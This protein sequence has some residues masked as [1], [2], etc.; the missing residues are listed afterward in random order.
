MFTARLC[1]PPPSPCARPC[2]PTSQ[3]GPSKFSILFANR[4]GGLSIADIINGTDHDDLVELCSQARPVCRVIRPSTL[5][6]TSP[7]PRSRTVAV[8]CHNARLGRR[9]L[10]CVFSLPHVDRS[11]GERTRRTRLLA[12]LFDRR[13]A[14]RRVARRGILGRLFTLRVALGALRHLARRATRRTLRHRRNFS[15]LLPLAACRRRVFLSTRC[16]TRLSIQGTLRGS[17]LT[18]AACK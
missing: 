11:L 2:P 3:T 13:V 12:L 15:R 1:L 5:T 10:T 8:P 18:L 7:T 6:M 4:T 17:V 14:C 16:L 9:A